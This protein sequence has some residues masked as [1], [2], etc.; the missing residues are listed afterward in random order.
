M[1]KQL[2]A[3]HP[4]HGAVKVGDT[5]HWKAAGKGARCDGVAGKIVSGVVYEINPPDKFHDG[6][7]TLAVKGNYKSMFSG[8]VV[9]LED[10]RKVEPAKPPKIGIG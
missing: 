2:K 10:V 1:T 7:V 5:V 9:F 4:V 3:I 6:K 8:H